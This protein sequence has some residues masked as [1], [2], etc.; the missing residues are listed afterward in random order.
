MIKL[1]V[2]ILKFIGLF[3]VCFL[4]LY[5]ISAVSSSFIMWENRFNMTLWSEAGRFFLILFT[6]LTGLP[7]FIVCTSGA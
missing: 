2:S 6:L 5:L 7:L 4:S 1:R 3:V